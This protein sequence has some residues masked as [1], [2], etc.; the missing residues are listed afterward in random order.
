[1]ADKA[2]QNARASGE[3]ETGPALNTYIS[4]VVCKVT[5][6][7][8]PDVR[9]YIMN[10]PFMNAS[11]A[12]NGYTE[13]W[14]GLLLRA[15]NE[16][17]LAF[18]IGH[19]TS[20]FVENHTITA[21]R[22]ER[23]RENALLV[24]SV[25]VAIAGAAAAGSAGSYNSASAIADSTRG[26][27]NALY[28]ADIAAF[29]RF[30]REQESQADLLGM[31][32]AA[33]AGYDPRAS[34][35]M[36][37]SRLA[38]TS[39]SDFERVRKGGA[40]TS[41][42]TDHPLDVDRVTALKGAMPANPSGDLGRDRYRAAIRPYLSIWLR[43]ELRRRDYGETLQVI[44]HLA[45]GGEDLGVL[46]FYSGECYRLRRGDGDL[47][48]ARQA[49]LEA[50]AYSDAPVGVWRELGETLMKIKNNAAA[51]SALE[52]YLMRAPDAPDAWLVREDLKGLN[53]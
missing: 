15:A 30:S 6:P 28:L 27:V 21:L 39:S 5:G 40:R 47:D 7:Y 52:T 41:I 53:L 50:S 26:L 24:L 46:K 19:E 42:F 3:V 9:V 17:E 20:H 10:R 14:S 33:D 45:E 25:G 23:S 11:M 44:N 4:G 22:A 43:D 13:I 31:K 1:M 2:E 18:V 8:C 35:S 36:W 16:A 49:Y 29:F 34:I 12:P 48:R 32:R 37:Q 51:K 38:E